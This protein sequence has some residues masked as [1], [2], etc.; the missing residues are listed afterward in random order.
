LNYNGAR[1][2]NPSL[3]RY[4][5][6]DPIGLAGGINTF[7]YVGGNS[8]TKVDPRGLW[9]V[10][11]EFYAPYGGGVMF[12]QNPN[13]NWFLTF[14]GGIGLG[15]GISYDPNGTSPGYGSIAGPACGVNVGAFGD[16]G[17]GLGPFAAGVSGEEGAQFGTQ[18]EIIPYY[19][20]VSAGTYYG[21]DMGWR[22]RAGGSVG[23]Q[24][25]F[26]GRNQ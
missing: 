13:G 3:G 23:G 20:Y 6:S 22:L 14:R 1:D 8:I 18:N 5:E 2:Y 11:G 26:G 25:T 16:A 7:A 19:P 21:L 15:G 4:I 24:I 12:G 9:S 10:T 17:L